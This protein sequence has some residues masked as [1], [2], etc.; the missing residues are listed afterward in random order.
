MA[1][2]TIRKLDDEVYAR[3]RA[4]AQRNDRSI[5]AEARQVLGERLGPD[6][7]ER[8]ERV[9]TMIERLRAQL[10]RQQMDPDYPGSVATIR[11]IRDEG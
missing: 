1:T 11:A 10:D 4:Q 5:E 6:E 3:L 7:A 9:R 2:L 8:S